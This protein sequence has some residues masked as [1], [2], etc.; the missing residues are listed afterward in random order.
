MTDVANEKIDFDWHDMK[1]LLISFA[2]T[3][4]NRMIRWFSQSCASSVTSATF[5][6]TLFAKTLVEPADILPETFEC[7]MLETDIDQMRIAKACK[8][9]CEVYVSLVPTL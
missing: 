5:C 9:R 1:S 2:T 4:G 8:T 6:D 3:S 7:D